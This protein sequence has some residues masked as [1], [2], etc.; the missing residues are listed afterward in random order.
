MAST[1]RMMVG[2]KI[3]PR[4]L[5]LVAIL[6]AVTSAYVQGADVVIRLD[7]ALDTI[8]SGDAHVEQLAEGYGIPEG[9]VW[10]S[11]GGYLLFSDIPANEINKW[12]PDG[13]VS[14][15][16]KPSGFTGTDPSE[17]GKEV[18]DKRGVMRS[19]GSNGVTLDPEGRVVFCASGDRAV[20]RLEKNGRRTVLADR[21]EGKRLNHPNDLVY[22]S[23][24][25]LYFT[26]PSS[27]FPKGDADPNRELSFNG[28]YLLRGKTLQA[29]DKTFSIPNGLAFS[30][31]EEYLYVNDTSKKTIVRFEVQPDDTISR[32]RVFIDMTSDTTPGYPDGMKVDR[33][34]NVYCTGPGGL[35]IMSPDG[36]HLGTIKIPEALTNL[37][38]G[39]ADGKTLYLTAHEGKLFRIR[40]KVE[41]IRP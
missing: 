11:Q 1:W 22:K 35:W 27:G 34:G 15:F 20:V 37:A 4:I 38:F 17:A 7:P 9:P 41:G 5:L 40:T 2:M 30:P 31:G 13:K 18:K 33:K 39:D 6:L 8:L 25:A 36:K 3:L 26:D 19:I 16:L 28:V 10:D 21:Y 12:T 23:D 32:G 14:V 29:L 24:G